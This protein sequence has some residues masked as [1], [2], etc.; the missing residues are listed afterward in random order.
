[1]AVNRRITA[2]LGT[3]SSSQ[4]NPMFELGNVGWGAR[5]RTWDG[6]TKNRCLTTWRRPNT[7]KV[8]ASIAKPDC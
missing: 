8:Q 5:I 1:M 7:G 2:Q 3:L 6:G 4:A